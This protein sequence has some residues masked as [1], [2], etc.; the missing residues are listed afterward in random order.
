MVRAWTGRRGRKE[1]GRVSARGGPGCVREATETRGGVRG[2]T[3]RL[4]RHARSAAPARETVLSSKSRCCRRRD[5]IVPYR[6]SRA[7]RRYAKVPGACVPRSRTCMDP[8][9]ETA[10]SEP[11]RAGEMVISSAN[12]FLSLRG[13]STP[14][15]ECLLPLEGTSGLFS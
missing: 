8:C 9:G 7:S 1:S 3:A 15:R 4:C 11:R 13:C 12:S 2:E 10:A 5:E 6:P 14:V